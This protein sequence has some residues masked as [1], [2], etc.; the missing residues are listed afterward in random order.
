[1]ERWRCE[2]DWRVTESTTHGWRTGGGGGGVGRGG[3][4]G[5]R[6]RGLR[7]PILFTTSP[8]LEPNKFA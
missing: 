6:E 2:E 7:L 3:R 4:E 8:S 5:G 1:M